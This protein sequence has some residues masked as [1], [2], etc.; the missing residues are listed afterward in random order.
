MFLWPGPLSLCY[1][2]VKIFHPV[3]KAA[4]KMRL[5]ITSPMKGKYINLE[6][7]IIIRMYCRLLKHECGAAAP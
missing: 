6:G 4:R 1:G 3:F 7:Y 2:L 5:L